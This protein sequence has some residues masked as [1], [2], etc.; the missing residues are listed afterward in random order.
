MRRS[1]LQGAFQTLGHL[2][3]FALTGVATAY[4]FVH[5]MW[6]PFAAALWCHGT[7]W[8]TKWLNGFFLEVFSLLSWHNHH[9]YAISHTYHRRYTLFPDGDRELLLPQPTGL[10]IRSLRSCTGG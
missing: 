8:R 5:S 7:V 2:A 1:N 3:L 9:E 10:S 4:F 6:L